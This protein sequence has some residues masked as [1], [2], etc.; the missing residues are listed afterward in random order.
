MPCDDLNISDWLSETGFP[1]RGIISGRGAPTERLAGFID[2]F[3]QPGMKGLETFL[4]DTKHTLRIIEEINERIDQGEFSLDG[5]GLVTM[6][7]ESMYNNITEDLGLGAVKK[8]LDC[9]QYQG[10]KNYA[11]T[12]PE[13]STNS[14]TEG[15]KLCLGNNF[16]KFNGKIYKQKGGVG[17]G[18]KLASPYACLAVGDFEK[19]VF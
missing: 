5:I 2:H 9:R 13:V 7:I 16:F 11:N 15:L 19:K 17:T 10:D 18:I 1:I 3:L 14:F 8:Y 6:D 12:D 4:Q